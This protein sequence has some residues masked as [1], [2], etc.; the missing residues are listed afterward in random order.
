MKFPVFSVSFPACSQL[1]CAQIFAVPS[2]LRFSLRA[3]LLRG[4][5][6]VNIFFRT[7]GNRENTGN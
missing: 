5:V 3:S 4:Q 1:Q 2:V 6:V 7:S